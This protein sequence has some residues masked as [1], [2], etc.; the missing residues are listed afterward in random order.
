[1]KL[2]VMGTAEECKQAQYFYTR[3]GHQSN[4]RFCTVSGLYP[5]RGSIGYY[6]VYFELE[7]KD[8][9]N[10]Y[11][12]EYAEERVRLADTTSYP[13]CMSDKGG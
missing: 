10:I 11:S 6:R 13:A 4:V 7:Y 12:E 8:G 2:R 9:S 5:N 3:L 1:M